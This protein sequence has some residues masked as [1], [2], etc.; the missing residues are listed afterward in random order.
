MWLRW[1]LVAML[2]CHVINETVTRNLEVIA[3]VAHEANQR[4]IFFCLE[5]IHHAR[6]ANCG[7]VLISGFHLCMAFF[8]IEHF[9]TCVCDQM[10]WPAEKWKRNNERE[11][12][13]KKFVLFSIKTI[14][15]YASLPLPADFQGTSLLFAEITESGDFLC[16]VFFEDGALHL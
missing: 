5:D 13:I 11:F 7:I 10:S 15:S 3:L 12:T 6:F 1:A 8:T 2:I 4:A 9:L 14:D 16:I